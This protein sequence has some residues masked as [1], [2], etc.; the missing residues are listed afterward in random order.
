M[1]PAER[2]KLLERL[3]DAQ[4]DHAEASAQQHADTRVKIAEIQAALGQIREAQR[5]TWVATFDRFLMRCTQTTLS[6]VAL[7]SLIAVLAITVAAVALG[8]DN[9]LSILA[10]NVRIGAGS[11]TTPSPA[12]EAP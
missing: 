9:V 10:G 12:L 5:L 11:D 4:I 7:F 3:V 6:T 8:S 1:T 2:D